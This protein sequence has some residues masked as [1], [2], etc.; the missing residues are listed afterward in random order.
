MVHVS[1]EDRH[2]LLAVDSLTAEMS[3][4][5][6]TKAEVATR[7]TKSYSTT[8]HHLR[9]LRELGAVEWNDRIPRSLRIAD[10]RQVNAAKRQGA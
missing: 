6:P 9:R 8:M 5:L 10:R 7:V 1:N 2:V 3:P 4:L